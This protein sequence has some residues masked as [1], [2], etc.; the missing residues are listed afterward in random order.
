MTHHPHSIQNRQCLAEFLDIP[1][2]HKVFL[3]FSERESLVASTI[4]PT[5]IPQGRKLLY[6]LKHHATEIS[7]KNIAQ[8]LHYGDIVSPMKGLD[9]MLQIAQEIYLPLVSKQES[10]PPPVRREALALLQNFLGNAYILAGQMQGKTLLST[11]SLP[12]LDERPSRM[13]N[14]NGCANGGANGH[15][16]HREKVRSF[17]YIFSN[18][19]FIYVYYSMTTYRTRWRMRL[20]SFS[21]YSK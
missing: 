3:Y 7:T 8:A 19:L 13:A 4:P 2:I 1:D 9:H 11:A 21:G 17:Y 18:I 20:L 12:F 15:R 16:H 6:F 14:G 5:R 10:L